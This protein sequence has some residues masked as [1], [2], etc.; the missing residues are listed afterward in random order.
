[1]SLYAINQALSNTFCKIIKLIKKTSMEIS[2]IKL[3]NGY[4]KFRNL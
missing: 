3:W 4:T 1:M 2:Y